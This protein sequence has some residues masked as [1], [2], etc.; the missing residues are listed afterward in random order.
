MMTTYS[1][2]AWDPSD[3]RDYTAL[4]V[5]YDPSRDE[6]GDNSM[7][8]ERPEV[9]ATYDVAVLIEEAKIEC[10]FYGPT[11]VTPTLPPV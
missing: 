8:Y 4:I 10:T 6:G 3:G 2:A 5:V 11:D 1:I 7:Q 9:L